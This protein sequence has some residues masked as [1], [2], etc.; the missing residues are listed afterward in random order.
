MLHSLKILTK[1]NL[2][3][4]NGEFGTVNDL[5]FDDRD[6]QIRY[7]VA[8]TG[9]W[10]PGRLVL[11]P[12]STFGEPDAGAEVF[13]VS[14]TKEQVKESPPISTDEPVSRHEERQVV[15]HAYRDQTPHLFRSPFDGPVAWVRPV[16]AADTSDVDTEEQTKTESGMENIHLRSAREVIGYQISTSDGELGEVDDFIVDQAPWTIRYLVVKTGTV[17]DSEKVLLAL[18]WVGDIDY[19][20]R[21]VTVDVTSRQVEESPRYDPSAVVERSYEEALHQYYQRKR[22][23]E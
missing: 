23:W 14:L 22:Y 13:P 10:L 19:H 20:R 8:D 1:Y 17:F 12:P 2:L 9:E 7:L 4:E 6:W 21:Q 5:L 15:L 3:A 16:A 18:P 11:L